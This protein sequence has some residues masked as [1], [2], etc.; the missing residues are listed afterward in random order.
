MR[1]TLGFSMLRRY[2]EVLRR[3]VCTRGEQ[4]GGYNR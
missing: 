3:V 2:T 4:P 1:V